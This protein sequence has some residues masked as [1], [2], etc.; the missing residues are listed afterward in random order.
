M[1][2]IIIIGYLQEME[3]L[4]LSGTPRTYGEVYALVR[5]R[6]DERAV[7]DLPPFGLHQK[8][9]PGYP[10]SAGGAQVLRGQQEN[11][12]ASARLRKDGGVSSS[13]AQF[14]AFLQ[15]TVL[16]TEVLVLKYLFH[17]AVL[18]GEGGEQK[19]EG[20]KMRVVGEKDTGGGVVESSS[21]LSLSLSSSADGVFSV[22]GQNATEGHAEEG[23]GKKSGAYF[24]SSSS[25]Q[26][27]R[28]HKKEE[29]EVEIPSMS[30][31]R[32]GLL[33]RPAKVL[34]SSS[35]S[36]AALYGPCSVYDPAPLHHH[37]D[38]ECFS[39]PHAHCLCRSGG[40]TGFPSLG[41]SPEDVLLSAATKPKEDSGN[42]RSHNVAIT[43]TTCAR[44]A[45][46]GEV[47]L[48]SSESLS[49]SDSQKGKPVA[50]AVG[51]YDL[52]MLR[53]LT[54]SRNTTSTATT[55]NHNRYKMIDHNRS[56]YYRILHKWHT[57][58]VEALHVSVDAKVSGGGMGVMRGRQETDGRQGNAASLSAVHAMLSL[59]ESHGRNY[60]AKWARRIRQIVQSLARYRW[61]AECRRQGLGVMVGG[62][63]SH[64]TTTTNH[65][66]NSNTI[67][68]SVDPLPPPSLST[69]FFCQSFPSLLLL[70]TP[71]ELAATSISTDRGRGVVGGSGGGRRSTSR[72]PL[73]DHHIEGNNGCGEGPQGD[74]R[75]YYPNSC[76]I[77]THTSSSSLFLLNDLEVLELVNA[78]PMRVM[79]VYRVVEDLTARWEDWA[80]AAGLTGTMIKNEE[81]GAEKGE[82]PENS[83]GKGETEE[84]IPKDADSFAERIVQVFHDIP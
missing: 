30:G 21:P 10:L 79:D 20:S 13:G 4:S 6:R 35:P 45:G 7:K 33:H 8:I 19:K 29:E 31:G 61:K 23:G 24:V 80:T 42:D 62:G 54:H 17:S 83:E 68:T 5:R 52:D 9:A 16:W 49:L 51:G 15:K 63:A 34:A 12:N 78:R 41:S 38:A 46:G 50:G 70:P 3:V 18:G 74:P 72:Y 48:P 43:S 67:T 44:P 47:T 27:V 53:S 55:A 40:C 84:E 37:Y 81:N 64:I 57:V 22:V 36:I 32:Q 28:S 66:N 25:P 71:L 26:E 60:E 39:A 65:N 82:E 58:L 69:S 2:F 77:L 75:V 76:G 56:C 14:S 59:Y 1:S 11:R 73:H